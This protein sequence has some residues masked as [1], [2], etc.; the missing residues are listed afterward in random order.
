M[1]SLLASQ[2]LCVGMTDP[3]M[4]AKKSNAIELESFDERCA[5]LTWWVNL[6]QPTIVCE[7]VPI[8][9]NISA[10]SGFVFVVT[11]LLL[12]CQCQYRYVWSIR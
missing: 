3:S 11:H 7:I 2:S 6:V 8:Q 4:L 5:A 9:G 1:S 12:E 10:L